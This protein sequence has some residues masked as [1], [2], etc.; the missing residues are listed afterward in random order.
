MRNRLDRKSNRRAVHER[1]RDKVR[2]TAARPRLAF[3][4]SASHVYAQVIDDD[5]GRTLVAAS[6]L[7]KS[8]QGKAPRK[9]NL[10]A[11]KAVG[12]AVAAAALE[13]SID[14]VVFDRGGYLY[15]G[16]VKALADAARARGLKF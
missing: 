3:Y 12:E 11:A 8:L 5:S 16:A 13:K 15:H 14:K 9:G 10:A 4:K 6:T 7:S 2:G 1:I